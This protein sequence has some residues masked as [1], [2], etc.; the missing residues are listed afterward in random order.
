MAKGPTSI[1][2]FA[3]QVG[4]GDCLLV[5]FSYP[6][7]DK[8]VL[9]D[10]GTTGLPADAERDQMKTIAKDIRERCGKSL[11]AVVA[12]HRH[13]D[14][15]SGFA[16]TGG[17]E[18][19][20]AIIAG[21]N[22]TL[23]IQPWTERPD[24]AKNATGLPEPLKHQ[25]LK[26]FAGSLKRMQSISKLALDSVA[27]SGPRLSTPL[28]DQ[29]TFIGQDN[30]PNPSAV[31][32]LMSMGKI[33]EY[34]YHGSGTSLGRYLP[35]VSV[36]VL[37]PPTLKQTDSIRKQRSRD[38]TEF[39]QFR[40][41][42]SK[43]SGDIQRGDME[44]FPKW[45]K[46]PRGRLPANARWLAR[47]ITDAQGDQ[48]LQLVRILD[49]QMNNTSV[50]LLFTVGGKTL[51]FPGDA[52]IENWSYALSKPS[53]RSALAAVDVYKVG[54]HGSLNATPKTMWNLFTKR[55]P[56][57]KKGRLRSVLSTM[58]GKHGTERSN[59]EVPRRT[60][61]KAL[62]TDSELHSTHLLSKDKLYEEVTIPI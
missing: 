34:V 35:G 31:K 36:D 14:H 45:P 32:G 59:T 40:H 56:K 11:V 5:R 50:I 1:T 17:E 4:F 27:A 38:D 51:L 60:L 53:V 57:N 23:V 25:S 46:T 26:G 15:I 10:F 42:L 2:I 62:T 44:L 6:Q 54:H 43:S 19:S 18:S 20:G 39:W 61:V 16:T 29:L 47:R 28:R 49:K 48:T 30:L 8:H 12:T 52:Q 21:L 3:Y 7:G 37:G 41:A 55:G 58:P 33:H 9:I 24:L 13:A 22:P